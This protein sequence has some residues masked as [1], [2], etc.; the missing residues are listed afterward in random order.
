MRLQDII[1]VD[2]EFELP[3]THVAVG[4]S[5]HAHISSGQNYVLVVVGPRSRCWEDMLPEANCIVPPAKALLPSL[6][7]NCF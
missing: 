6:W 2:R 3:D 7:N 4:L 1:Q 5:V